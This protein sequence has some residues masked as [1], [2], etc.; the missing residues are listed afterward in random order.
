MNEVDRMLSSLVAADYVYCRNKDAILRA[1]DDTHQLNVDFI[2]AFLAE[3]T[4]EE[5]TR[6]IA[7]FNKKHFS[8]FDEIELF[9]L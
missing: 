2:D 1:L 4:L 7:T 6:T 8:R 5:K 9:A 3:F